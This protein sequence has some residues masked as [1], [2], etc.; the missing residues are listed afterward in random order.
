[1]KSLKHRLAEFGFHSNQDF[2]YPI[3]CLLASPADRIRSLDIQGR[4]GR[5]KTAFAHALAHAIGDHEVLYHEFQPYR[6]QPEP[7][8][9]PDN[10]EEAHGE[11]PVEPLDQT[12][13]EACALSEGDR[14]ILILDQLQLAPF[15]QHLRIADFIKTGIWSYADIKLH[16]NPANLMIFMVSEESLFHSLQQTSFRVWVD[17]ESD[18]NATPVTSQLLGLGSHGQDL[19][20]ALNSIFEALGL[21]PSLQEYER[22]IRDI[23][24][25]VRTAEH[26]KLSLYGW[27]EDLDRQH[28]Y[29]AEI[30]E[31][32]KARMP[33]I[34]A[35]LGLDQE[36]IILEFNVPIDEQGN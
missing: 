19:V 4:Q 7:V 32:I 35:F 14:T 29:S 10:E 16:A 28:L 11:Q 34:E 17:P 1:M 15:V 36:P 33:V 23:Q 27:T 5:R 30:D 12:I 3:Q 18:D 26:L 8:K 22:L 13:S 9:L 24:L 2:D 6:E 20:L 25:H 21:Q 31:L